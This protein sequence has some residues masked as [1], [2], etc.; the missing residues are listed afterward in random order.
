MSKL[1]LAYN[2]QSNIKSLRFPGQTA[3]MYPTITAST[4]LAHLFGIV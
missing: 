2:Q 3:C 4:P 1:S